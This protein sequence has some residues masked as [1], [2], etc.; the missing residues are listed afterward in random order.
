MSGKRLFAVSF[1]F[2]PLPAAM[3]VVTWRLLRYC[4]RDF[5]V[6]TGDDGRPGDA[7]LLPLSTAGALRVLPVPFREAPVHLLARRILYRS[8]LSQLLQIPDIYRPW[9]VPA[10]GALLSM[11]PVAGDILVT[12]ASP[13]STHLSGLEAVHSV[14]GL[15][16]AAYFGDPWVTNP[17]IRRIAPARRLHARLERAVVET[18][19]LLVFP[20]SEMRDLTLSGYPARIHE[21]ARVVTHGWEES[22]Y[23][24]TVPPRS[25]GPFVVRHLGSLYGSRSPSDLVSAILLLMERSPAVL[26]RL[27]FEFY[28]P[29]Q[30]D[31]DLPGLPQG[32]VTFLPQVPY[33][34]SLALMA[35]A[36]ALLVITPSEMESGAFL[37][38]K[39]IDYV[40]AGRPVI[41]ICRPGAC[42]GL[43]ERLGGWVCA[44][45]SPASVADGLVSLAENLQGAGSRAT[46]WGDPEVRASLRAEE[47]GRVFGGFLEELF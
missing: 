17:M 33:L 10:A 32:L 23:P 2:P 47:T 21:K 19:D 27:R 40:G 20:C 7:G 38:S 35:S 1:A 8:S 31:V 34:D 24:G 46:A 28:G 39:L 26:E 25:G 6:V 15:R 43:L 41:G 45:G 11:K 12:F 13:M 5:S 37:P 9:A 30:K 36:D 4:G 29:L 3:S 42:T 44:T 18:A 22:L 16:W 14:P